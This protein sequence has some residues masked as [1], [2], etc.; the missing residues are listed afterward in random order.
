MSL[1]LARH[2]YRVRWVRRSPMEVQLTVRMPMAVH[3]P[4]QTW[5]TLET[6]S[7]SVMWAFVSLLFRRDFGEGL[8]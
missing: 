2:L 8:S 4:S 6:N 1:D 7:T 5:A 3:V